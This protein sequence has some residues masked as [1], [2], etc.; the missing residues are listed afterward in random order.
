MAELSPEA[1]YQAA[2]QDADE[3]QLAALLGESLGARS[4]IVHWMSDRPEILS[5]S[6]FTP[7]LIEGFREHAHLDPW[8]RAAATRIQPGRAQRMTRFVPESH[9]LGSAFFNEFVVAQG[10]DTTHCMG[11][12]FKTEAGWGAVALH[13]G[14]S[15]GDFEDVHEAR[16]QQLAPDLER[17]LALRGRLIAAERRALRLAESLDALSAAVIHAGANGAVIYANAAAEALLRRDNGLCV[18]AGVLRAAEP[19]ARARL[20]H[21]LHAATHEGRGD[22]FALSRSDGGEPFVATVMPLSRA[23][24]PPVALLVLA[25]PD[26][27]HTPC[28]ERLRACYGLTSAEA[29]VCRALSQG[30]SPAEIAESRGIQLSTVRTLLKHAMQKTDTTRQAELVSKLS[31][32]TLVK[33]ED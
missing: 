31:A 33:A 21:A 29:A 24:G 22:A 8:T 13:R 20:A 23:A 5:S 18:H 12:V 16:L 26:T 3:G 14:R 25:D 11:L 32:S 19:D 28:A 15:Q 10:D 6:Y 17:I 2:F 27:V 9:Y 4:A 30:L 7:G 1:L